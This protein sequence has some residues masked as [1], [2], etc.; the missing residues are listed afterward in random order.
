[1]DAFLWLLSTDP[2]NTPQLFLLNP[3]TLLRVAC[4][5]GDFVST[6]VSPAGGV[7]VERTV[8]CLSL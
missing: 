6:W 3:S 8:Q 7:V 2:F 4:G 1:M 5:G